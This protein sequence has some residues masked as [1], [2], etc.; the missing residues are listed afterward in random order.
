MRRYDGIC[1]YNA[2]SGMF[3]AMNETRWGYA[4]IHHG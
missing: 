2:D 1:A 4:D 3:D